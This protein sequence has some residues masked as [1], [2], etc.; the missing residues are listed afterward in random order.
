MYKRQAFSFTGT[1]TAAVFEC[2]LDQGL[3][4]PCAS[5]A[6]YSELSKGTHTFQVRAIDSNGF[7][8]L[9]PATANWT[10]NATGSDITISSSP[11]SLTGEYVATFGF[12]GSASVV[13]FE[14]SLD[15]GAFVTCVSPQTYTNLSLGEHTF[16]VR[17]VNSANQP[18][19]A[20]RFVWKVENVAPVALDQRVTGEP[21]RSVGITL[22]ATD[23]DAVVYTLVSAPAH[24]VLTGLAP[25]LTYTPDTDFTGSD[26]F[27]FRASDGLA[28]S[29]LATVTLVIGESGTAEQRIY[30]PVIQ[31]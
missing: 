20:A 6:V 21:N 4:Q 10:V 17:S 12:S 26:S 23:N 9:S 27:T 1:A 25:N 11:A 18:G 7:V 3:Y 8:D 28:E 29:N 2:Q 15:G 30:L 13:R 22:S 31:R 24:G 19:T 16:L 5:P 14:C